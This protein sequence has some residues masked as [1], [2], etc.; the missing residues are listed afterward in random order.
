VPDLP[1]TFVVVDSET[2]G[3]D[4]ARDRIIDLGAVR[5]DARLHEID[6]FS[7]LVRADV[8]VPLAIT[9][10]TGIDD[11]DLAGAPGFTEVYHAFARFADD[12]L[13]VGHNAAF[14]RAH[15]EAGARRAGLSF[16]PND[17]FDTLDAALLLLP[18]H[19]RHAL[20][21]LAAELGFERTSHRALPDAVSTADLLR[22]LA[23]RVAGLAAEERGL[24]EAVRWAPLRVLDAVAAPPD[25]APSPLV[26]DEPRGAARGG[27]L[28]TLPCLV[29][30]WQAELGLDD[31]DGASPATAGLAARLPGYRPRAGQG[32]MAGA[33]AA[34]LD[35][36]GVGL[37]EA[38]TGMGKSL[39]Y[40]LPV[41][42]ASAATG[43][44]VV[45]STKTKA[46]QRQLAAH[47]LP[48]VA[49]A[50][51]PGWNWAILMGRENYLCRRRLDE[52]VG[53][54]TAALPDEGRA[55]ALA[56][57]VGRA[58]WG[59]VDLSALPYRAQ[60]E[61]PALAELARELRSSR[62]TCLGRHCPARRTCHWRL[63]R[64]RAEA[65]H[66]VCVNHALLLTGREMLP[67]FEHV[68]VDEAHL[69][70]A[71]ATS[72]F[73][74]E[75]DWRSL[76]TLGRS[77]RG[78]GRQ[79]PLASRL[80]ALERHAEPHQARALHAA[81]DD[82]DRLL[83]DLPG[84]ARAI[85]EALVPVAQAARAAADGDEPATRGRARRSSTATPSWGPLAA[86]DYNLA[87]WL[88]PGL[89]ETAAWDT[90][91][92]ATAV[93][94]ERLGAVAASAASA[95]ET[96]PD[97]HRERPALLTLAEDAD[98]AGGL[99]LDLP[100]TSG[101]G[102]VLWAEI[103]APEAGQAAQGGLVAG[104]RWTLTRTPLTPAHACR[105][106]LWERLR[107]AVL[108]SATLTVA[109]S[110][111]YFRETTGLT[112]D[113]D[114][115]ERVFPS[116][117]DYARQAVLVL[118]HDPGS[119]WRAD[120]LAGRQTAR[121]KRLSE[122]T[123]GRTLALFT[124]KRDMHQVAA[125][126]G[127]HVE[128]DGVLVLAQGM[129]GSAAALAE[130]FRAHPETILLGVD[131]LWTGQDFPGDARVCLGIAKLPF[132]RQDPLVQARRQACLEEGLDW[133]RTFYLPE[134]VL[135]FRQGFGRLIRTETDV[136]VI[137]VLDHRVTQQAY[138]R[139]FLDSLPPVPVVQASPDEVPA[140]VAAHLRR[141]RSDPGLS[142]PA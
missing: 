130:E 86:G 89:R 3:L 113:L 84:L 1:L 137:V 10:M 92:T 135:R 44:R 27:A 47:E 97:D 17:W 6:R 112:G 71:E 21:F 56:Y 76:E 138:G 122:V 69:L 59:E 25:Q 120:E 64:S 126:V 50:L 65:A 96:L 102:A 101:P 70:P 133:F 54:E 119:G 39:A 103:E 22:R 79:R 98:R 58:R 8:P 142:Q 14:D 12:A 51:P 4:P 132:P 123:G 33:V 107:G 131:S 18:E 68:V 53:A 90:L 87:A 20:P 46:L 49:A 81:A 23:G 94:A 75:V 128:D 91:A 61:L 52:A 55:A 45:V 11:D 82:A 37:F 42:F 136:G 28:T 129:H 114:V 117:F 62:A 7:S 48:L 60:R 66:L 77:L 109:G 24:L 139:D 73:S 140:V 80:R 125:A 88:T 116:P 104:P 95:A 110:F 141:L 83:G 63:A 78:P 13:L 5:L 26:A 16:L 111:A 36:G 134:A 2:T 100:E 19:D 57:L 34:I 121:L 74:D 115:T 31:A 38:G 127:A 99:L 35:Q 105:E 124:N 72:A 85:G 93:L 43:R 40:L 15:L 118:E 108:T 30:D 41:A 9:R 106:A 29:D 32:E 67:P